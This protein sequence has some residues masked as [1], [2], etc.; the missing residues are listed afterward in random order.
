MVSPLRP[1][2]ALAVAVAVFAAAD[3]SASRNV[4]EAAAAKAAR[5]D[6]GGLQEVRQRVIQSMLPGN[7]TSAQ[8]AARQLAAQL[9]PNGSWPDIDYHEFRR[10]GWPMVQHLV[11]VEQMAAAWRGSNA[12][13]PPVAGA[14]QAELL[15]NTTVA[16]ELW[17][18][19]D[20]KNPNWYDNEI[21]V[22]REMGRI[23]LLLA[24]DALSAQDGAKMTEIMARADWKGRGTVQSPQWTGAN[25][26]DMLRIQIHRGL[27]TNDT[28]L[29]AQAFTRSFADVVP[30][31]Q[32][33][34]SIQVD[35]SFHQVNFHC[36]AR[37][38]RPVY[39]SPDIRLP[40]SYSV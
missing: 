22:P 39:P 36:S 14:A 3:L 13:T 2:R 5:D 31:S 9:C 18:N 32:S 29:V 25:L 34:E 24:P 19:N 16:L 27:F 17:L 1:L 26:L 6:S 40:R 21:G 33:G 35:H 30:H 37:Q 20:W 15:G 12:S 23:G 8:A 11:R 28:A 7:A 4:V 10:A 38:C